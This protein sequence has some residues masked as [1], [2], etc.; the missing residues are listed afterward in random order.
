MGVKGEGLGQ[1]LAADP[2]GGRDG[3]RRGVDFLAQMARA[4]CSWAAWA[5]NPSN[6]SAA[7]MPAPPWMMARTIGW[8]APGWAR[9]NGPSAAVRS[10]THGPS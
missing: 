6:A 5:W 2:I 8:M 1:D 9:R 10:A 3:G 7:D 4:A